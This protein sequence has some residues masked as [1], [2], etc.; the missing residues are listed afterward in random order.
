MIIWSFVL[1]AIGVAALMNVSIWPGVLIA[2]G[3]STLLSIAFRR[4]RELSSM[5][6]CW[7]CWPTFYRSE[8]RDSAN[9]RPE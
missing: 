5:F 4:N 2:L 9:P 1:I 8:H 7:S 6:N 3:V